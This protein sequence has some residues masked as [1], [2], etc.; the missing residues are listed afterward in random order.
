MLSVYIHIPFCA[1]KCAYCGFYSTPYLAEDAGLFLSSLQV[2]VARYRNYL[3]SKTIKSIYVGGG[4]PTVLSRQQLSTLLQ[5]I[6]DNFPIDKSTEFTV[7]ANPESAAGNVFS[8]L[9]AGG[10]NRVSIGIQSFSDNILAVLGRPHTAD[11]AVHA[12]LAARAA[13]F[14]NISADLIYGIPGQTAMEWEE[15]LEKTM[16]LGPEHISAYGLSL[17]HSSFFHRE[18]AAGRFSLPDEDTM[19][20]MYEYAVSRLEREGYGRYE[21]S[22]FSQAGFECR[23]N[24]NYW[25]RGD[26]LGLGPGA[27]SLLGNQR[28]ANIADIHEYA[29][30][31]SQGHEPVTLR[32]VID[33]RSIARE[34]VFLGIRTATGV[35]MQKFKDQFG[36]DILVELEHNSIQLQKAGLIDIL[37]GCMRLTA[38]GIPVSDAVMARLSV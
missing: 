5:I 16:E 32:E 27:C 7:E 4:T 18:A 36:N 15:T 8:L 34:V 24:L 20:Q 31:L 1:G 2:E 33:I 22:N 17:D 12:F 13:G 19:V 9:A 14:K 6:R 11:D 35:D 37:N 26:Y 10:V 3:S 29:R 38:R 21:I 25:C 23:H 28:S 30:L